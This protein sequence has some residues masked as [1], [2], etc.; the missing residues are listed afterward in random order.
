[1]KNLKKT[2]KLRRIIN[3]NNVTKK[4]LSLRKKL[5]L[6]PKRVQNGGHVTRDTVVAQIKALIDDIDDIEPSDPPIMFDF[7]PEELRATVESNMINRD[8]HKSYFDMN[9]PDIAFYNNWVEKTFFSEADQQIFKE[10]KAKD[11]IYK[12]KTE[13]H[14]RII[15]QE[16]E[17]QNTMPH[18]EFNNFDAPYKYNILC[19]YS[20]DNCQQENCGLGIIYKSK[21]KQDGKSI[22]KVVTLP[23][24]NG[25][26]LKLRD[27]YFFHFTPPLKPISGH[28]IKR[29]LIRDYYCKPL[30]DG[31]IS[32][33][34]FYKF[35]STN[36]PR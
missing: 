34:D 4:K 5:K 2:L 24:M 29:T 8:D 23:V 26:T 1:M 36:M 16:T 30:E 20:I 14:L 13:T 28:A 18:R 7:L 25:L 32:E 27:K 31:V 3:K 33:E 15:T 9:D 35:M 17:T 11:E 10:Q 19:Y 6:S 12:Y 21:E 22:L